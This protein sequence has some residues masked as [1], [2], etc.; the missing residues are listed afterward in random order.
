MTLSVFE[1]TG[2]YAI[3][4]DSG[5]QLYDRIYPP[6]Q[7]GQAITLDFNG[8]NVFASA[9]FNFAIGQLLR[10][11]APADLNRL[12]HIDGLNETGKLLLKRVI[13]NAKRY[14]T[15]P[16][17]QAAVDDTLEEYAQM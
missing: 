1:I 17:Y 7:A 15:D 12:L 2:E 10:D 5:Q 3:A 4:S 11:L 16:Q 6:L 9:F 13:D 14:Y 8:V